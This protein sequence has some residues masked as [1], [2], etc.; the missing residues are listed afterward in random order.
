MSQCPS[1]RLAAESVNMRGGRNPAKMS[2]REIRRPYE[3]IVGNF[4]LR[5]SLSEVIGEAVAQRHT[6]FC[7]FER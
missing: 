7:S 5:Q 1:P 6:I 2:R 4:S 3:N